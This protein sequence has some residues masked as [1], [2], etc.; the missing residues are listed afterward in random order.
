MDQRYPF[1]GRVLAT[2]VAPMAIAHYALSVLVTLPNT[3]PYRLALLPVSALLTANGLL[4]WDFANGDE[5]ASFQNVVAV[6]R[7]SSPGPMMEYDLIFF[8]F[9]QFGVFLVFFS[10]LIWGWRKDHYK[11]LDGPQKTIKDALINGLDLCTNPTALGWE[12]GLKPDEAFIKSRETMSRP[13]FVAVHLFW[14]FAWLIILDFVKFSSDL[15]NTNLKDLSGNTIF[16]PT[17][18]FL[19]RYFKATLFTA[20]FAILLVGGLEMVINVTKVVS[21]G[22]LGVHP[23]RCPPLFS[24]PWASTSLRRLWSKGWHQ[25][26]RYNFLTFGGKPLARI[27]NT[28][29]VG[30]VLGTCILSG[31]VHDVATMSLGSGPDPLY[32]TMFFLM[33]GVGTILEEQ[34][35]RTT[36][37]KVVG[38]WGW[39]W[40]MIWLGGWGN[41]I[42]D[43][44]CRR[45]M[46]ANK[47]AMEEDARPSKKLWNALGGRPLL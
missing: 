14:T 18:P 37:K 32:V 34:W 47:G 21:V 28:G 1:T 6:V 11:R 20:H 46:A 15:V 16:D 9:V 7:V 8:F 33:M 35:S 42:I 44:W 24:Q 17:L 45:G 19:Q 27:T 36:G 10:G 43:A 2:E 4:H 29:K 3:R 38:L 40:T 12:H 13:Y 5:R 30:I 23:K 31:L 22:I 41:L 25:H 39:L 26:A